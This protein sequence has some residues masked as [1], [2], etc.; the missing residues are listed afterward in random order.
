MRDVVIFA[1]AP[2]LGT[3]K[4]R[5]AAGIGDAAA[6]SIYRRMLQGVT[7]RLKRGDW[8]LRLAVTPDDSL[9]QDDLWPREVPR[10]AQGGGDLGA[11]MLRFLT[12]ATPDAPV[13]IVG[14]DI[15]ELSVEHVEQAFAALTAKPLVF[16]PAEDGGFYLIGTRQAPPAG[17]FRGVAWS[18]ETVLRDSILNCGTD[19]VTLID[20]L[21]DLDDVTSLKAL[22]TLDD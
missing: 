16:G 5:L 9:G 14:S 3:V 19:S 1:K 4:T 2:V 10:L 11:R 18:T 6:L 15:P 7:A 21:V 8:R 17:L 20:T 22:K 13:V 12:S